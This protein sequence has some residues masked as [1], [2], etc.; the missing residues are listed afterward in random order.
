MPRQGLVLGY[1]NL[2]D[3]QVGEGVA[4]LATAIH[5]LPRPRRFAY[6]S[7]IGLADPQLVE[8]QVPVGVELVVAH[9]GGKNCEYA[10][11]VQRNP[12]RLVDDVAVDGGP[13]NRLD[14]QAAGPAS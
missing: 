13:A 10:R 2:A 14:R 3:H 5:R 8:E 11:V 12:R 9:A 4:L 7:L 6:F 1:G